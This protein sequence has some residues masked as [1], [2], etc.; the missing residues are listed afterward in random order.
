MTTSRDL[1]SV[2]E[3]YLVDG[4]TEL[5]DRSYDEVRTSIDTIKQRVVLGPWRFPS[6]PT[7][8]RIGAVGV[9]VFTLSVAGF[10]LAPRQAGTGGEASPSPS[11]SPR[12]IPV[13][14][15]DM[16]ALEPGTYLTGD[17][18]LAR[19]TFTLPDGPVAWQGNVSGPYAV[20]LGD[21]SQ[22]LLRFQVFDTV[23]AEPCQ[24]DNVAMNPQPGPSVDDLANA[25]ASLPGLQVTPPTDVTFGGYQGKQ[26][27][28]TAPATGGPC[29]AWILPLGATNDMV[30]GEQQRVWILDVDG[31]RLVI[32][33]PETST[34]TADMKVDV[35]AVLDSI[36]I[37]PAPPSESPSSTPA[38]STE[39]TASPAPP[40]PSV[41]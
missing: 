28:L 22:D 11:A 15:S 23:Y 40:S 30:A 3:H 32:D 5:P 35:Q 25:L 24:N 10:A 26:L 19:V 33:A 4:P 17:P 38:G 16:P 12:P 37:A 20:W 21:A 31:Q 14:S 2:L 29:R 41:S 27:T 34:V 6:M 13:T 8:V 7:F 39:A 1:K 18:F 36:R 9:V